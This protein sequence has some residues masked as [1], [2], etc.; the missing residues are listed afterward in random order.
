LYFDLSDWIINYEIGKFK[1]KTKNILGYEYFKMN[2]KETR[3]NEKGDWKIINQHELF[4]TDKLK[5]V[6]RFI[7]HLWKPITELCIL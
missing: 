1:S 6:V 7:I 3:I 2:M 5:L 4:V